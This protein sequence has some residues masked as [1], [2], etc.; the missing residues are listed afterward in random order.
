MIYHTSKVPDITCAVWDIDAQDI[1][2]RGIGITEYRGIGI[3]EYRGIGIIEYR[4][5]GITECRGIGI[6][7]YRGI[8][9]CWFILFYVK[10]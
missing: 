7:E 6:I 5:I 1:E 10:W 4:G 2:F 9:I 8:G 3:I